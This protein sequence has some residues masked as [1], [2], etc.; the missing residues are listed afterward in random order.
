MKSSLCAAGTSTPTTKRLVLL[1]L[2]G[3][4]GHVDGSLLEAEELLEL[5]G[6]GLLGNLGDSHG[7]LDALVIVHV[8]GLGALQ[9]T[10]VSNVSSA[11]ETKNTRNRDRMWSTSPRAHDG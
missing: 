3:D 1:G 9:A 5:L 7:D 8:V 4:L 6:G 10:R 2:G 11:V